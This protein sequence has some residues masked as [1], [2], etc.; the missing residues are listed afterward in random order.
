[1]SGTLRVYVNSKPVEAP[2]G[3]T[4]LDA[5]RALDPSLAEGVAAGA[6]I[7]TDSRGLPIDA[8]VS[9]TQ[10]AIFRVIHARPASEAQESDT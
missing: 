4:A 10:G 8:S 5:V 3:G 1:M 9:L 2:A 6:R 7:V